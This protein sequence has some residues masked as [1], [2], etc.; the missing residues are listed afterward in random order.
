MKLTR[1]LLSSA[2][3]PVLLLAL[4]LPTAGCDKIKKATTSDDGKSKLDLD[5]YD[6]ALLLAE[7]H[8]YDKAI[9][10]LKQVLEDTPDD[11]R[12][13]TAMYYLGLSYQE[14]DDKENAIAT[15]TKFVKKY[16]KHEK[17]ET[18]KANLAKK[19]GVAL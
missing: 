15:Y 9:P 3:I 2:L 8:L 18:A 13:G 17:A 1:T 7:T 5:D 14:E 12:A 4:L 6:K 19:F 16:P 10:A 11:K